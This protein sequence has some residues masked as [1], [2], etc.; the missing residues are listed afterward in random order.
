MA[1]GGWMDGC[2]KTAQEAKQMQLTAGSDGTD[3][4]HSDRQWHVDVQK[5]AED[6]TEGSSRTDPTDKDT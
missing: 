5:R 3:G 6:D 4:R 1:V 2:T